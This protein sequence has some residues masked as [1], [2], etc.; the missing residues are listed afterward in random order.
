MS[1]Q[2]KASPRTAPRNGLLPALWKHKLWWMPPLG[3]L[4]ILLG[5]IY[6]LGHLSRTDSEMYPTTSRC[7]SS[8]IRSC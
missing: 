4:L 2:V 5:A 1:T 7:Y 8:L 3:V 6:V